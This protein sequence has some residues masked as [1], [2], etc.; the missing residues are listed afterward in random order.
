MS[1]LPNDDHP[2]NNPLLSINRDCTIIQKIGEEEVEF[3]GCKDV[4]VFESGTVIVAGVTT[5]KVLHPAAGPIKI[6]RTGYD[7]QIKDSDFNELDHI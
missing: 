7:P 6:T 2:A 3:S 4:Y 1:E 5:D